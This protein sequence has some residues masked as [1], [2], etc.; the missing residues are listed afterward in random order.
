MKS[1]RINLLK[2]AG[3][4]TVLIALIHIGCIVFGGDWY[5]FLGAGEQ[6]AQL[7]ERGDLYPTIVTSII[8]AVLLLWAI[9][10]FSGAG[11]IVKLPLLRLGL[12]LISAVLLI[13][14]L[15]FYFIMPAFPDNSLTFWFL[16]SGICL[17]LGLTYTL[18]LK[19]R[20]HSISSK[21]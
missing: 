21:A 16:S 10:A 18:G 5:R 14:A 8:S 6:M 1:Q 15:G 11:L 13:R 4:L 12:A 20:W 19:Q 7:A 9:Y 17:L 2:I 3:I